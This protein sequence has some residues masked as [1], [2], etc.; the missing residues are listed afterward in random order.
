MPSKET[1]LSN[2]L[3]ANLKEIGH[4]AEEDIYTWAQ[5]SGFH[6]H[7]LLNGLAETV[8]DEAKRKTI[9]TEMWQYFHSVGLNRANEVL[10]ITAQPDID[11]IN[12]T[13]AAVMSDRDHPAI[14]GLGDDVEEAIYNWVRVFSIF[15]FAAYTFLEKHLGAKAALVIY[16]EYMWENFALGALDHVKEA[17]GIKNPEDVDMDKLGQLSRLYW[18]AIDCPYHVTQHSQDVH[19]AE[20]GDCPYWWNMRDILGE[21]KCRSMSLKT[22]AATSVNYYDAILKAL[23]VFDKY[24]FTMDKFQ[25]CGDDVCRVRFE[26]RR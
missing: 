20:L 22:L 6:N 9:L 4:T 12:A 23:G 26:R 18:E 14:L 17:V 19:E 1:V 5:G 11:K 7:N 8:E 16:T 2:W 15:D 21:E 24:S 3:F 25:C 13:W 10:G